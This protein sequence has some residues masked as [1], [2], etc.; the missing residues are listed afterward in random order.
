M[1]TFTFRSP[2]GKTVRVTA[3]EGATQAE[4]WN[5]A[6]RQLELSHGPQQGRDQSIVPPG[7]VVDRPLSQGQAFDVGRMRGVPEEIAAKLGGEV[8]ESDGVLFWRP[9]G[10][11]TWS[12][13]NP[14]GLDATDPARTAGEAL[15]PGGGAA[16][17][18][19]AAQVATKNP[20]VRGLSYAAGGGLGSAINEAV[21]YGEGTQRE[22]P[23]QAAYMLSP[24]VRYPVGRRNAAELMEAIEF[25]EANPAFPPLLPTDIMSR[26]GLPGTPVPGG[27][28]SGVTK[29]ADGMTGIISGT[30]RDMADTA[31]S[32]LETEGFIMPPEAR[33]AV[34]GRVPGQAAVERA[35][36]GSHHGRGDY[37][38][39]RAS[40]VGSADGQSRRD[41]RGYWEGR[42]PE[43]RAVVLG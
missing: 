28:V 26:T 2:E 13:L 33:E 23:Q 19:I 36:L 12:R 32:A 16:A 9:E 10:E 38:P 7:E 1:P 39:G 6:Q 31:Q 40:R 15:G 5:M 30:R 29:Q 24:K 37:R 8:V 18:R 34:Q 27:S 25:Q 11:T 20:W 43:V 14:Q 42:V 35:D 21:Q 17:A 41:P 22:T 3:P 4:A